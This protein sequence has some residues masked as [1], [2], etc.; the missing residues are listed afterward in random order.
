MFSGTRSPKTEMTVSADLSVIALS[1]G[2]EVA[3]SVASSLISLRLPEHPA[4]PPVVSATLVERK[5][6]RVGFINISRGRPGLN[7]LVR[8]TH[9]DYSN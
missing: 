2:A 1:V 7:T 4:N 9:S 6:R 8:V 5:R 3:V